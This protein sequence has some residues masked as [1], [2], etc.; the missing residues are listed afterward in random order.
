MSIPQDAARLA[1]LAWFERECDEDPML[2]TPEARVLAWRAWQANSG[3]NMGNSQV[4][5]VKLPEPFAHIMP[6]AAMSI[7][8]PQLC[9]VQHQVVLRRLKVEPEA[10]PLYTETQVLALLSSAGIVP[11]QDPKDE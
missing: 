3:A 8:R 5:A 1:F 10:E 6:S 2:E 4:S 9:L 7:L 11:A